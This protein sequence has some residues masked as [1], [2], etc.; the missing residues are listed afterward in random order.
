M[1]VVQSVPAHGVCKL[2]ALIILHIGQQIVEVIDLVG[3]KIYIIL[4]IVSNIKVLNLN[5][6]SICLVDSQKMDLLAFIGL[7]YYWMATYGKAIDGRTGNR[8]RGKHLNKSRKK[9]KRKV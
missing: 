4:L 5:L 2:G 6:P 8:K 1:T 3:T 7:D 9:I